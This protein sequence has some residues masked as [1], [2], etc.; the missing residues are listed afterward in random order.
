MNF[1]VQY[2]FGAYS[3]GVISDDDRSVTLGPNQHESL[4]AM[5]L[6]FVLKYDS[7]A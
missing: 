3:A 6:V 4:Q 5:I 1:V 7:K 2:K